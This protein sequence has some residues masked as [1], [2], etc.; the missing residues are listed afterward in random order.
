M[1][2]RSLA[3]LFG[4][5]SWSSS[6][7]AEPLSQDAMVQLWPIIVAH[8]IPSAVVALRAL[9]QTHRGLPVLISTALM[10]CIS[11]LSLALEAGAL[12]LFHSIYA[13]WLVLTG[14]TLWAFVHPLWTSKGKQTV[15]G[16]RNAL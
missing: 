5:L 6:V 2:H 7:G 15:R 11:L 9:R 1:N 12:L 3:Y 16:A 13:I 8:L 10:A 14:L 4:A